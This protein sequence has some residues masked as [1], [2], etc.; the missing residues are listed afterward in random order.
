L[1]QLPS[2]R[3]T[4]QRSLQ[5]MSPFIC[6]VLFLFAL[7]RNDAFRQYNN[8]RIAHQFSNVRRSL[9]S[10]SEDEQSKSNIAATTSKVLSELERK[11][12]FH[13]RRASLW[14]ATRFLRDHSC[15]PSIALPAHN[16]PSDD[17]RMK[18][19][20]RLRESRQ[21]KIQPPAVR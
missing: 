2:I 6:V 14:P 9:S 12:S 8:N 4:N 20:F 10:L 3:D 7:T 16:S 1:D 19:D 5:E 13:L 11:D 15:V 18:E 21:R 17:R